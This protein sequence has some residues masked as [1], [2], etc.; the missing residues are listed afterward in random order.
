VE[1]ATF[2][3]GLHVAA[4]EITKCLICVNGVWIRFYLLI[5]DTQRE[6]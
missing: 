1:D 6:V 4:L 2:P 3:R 5:L